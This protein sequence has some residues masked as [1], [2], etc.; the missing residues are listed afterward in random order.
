MAFTREKKFTTVSSSASGSVREKRVELRVDSGVTAAARYAGAGEIRKELKLNYLLDR[1]SEPRFR[2]GDAVIVKTLDGPDAEPFQAVCL[3]TSLSGLSFRCS[4]PL[5][6]GT[7]VEVSLAE[8]SAV[9]E[10]RYCTPLP[11]GH[12]RV[13]VSLKEE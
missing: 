4:V 5:P 11:D 3:D 7:N 9:A 12:F 6:N 10:V 13:G 1:R 2:G 8:Y